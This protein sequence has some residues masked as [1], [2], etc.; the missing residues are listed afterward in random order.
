MTI[1]RFF[2]LDKERIFFMYDD[3]KR[4]KHLIFK[5]SHFLFVSF[6]FLATKQQ[7]QQQQSVTHLH[8]R[9][10]L[11]E[12]NGGEYGACTGA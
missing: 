11:R 4:T 9:V 2:F 1:S 12:S 5:T 10:P 6:I 7:Q 3:N 8:E